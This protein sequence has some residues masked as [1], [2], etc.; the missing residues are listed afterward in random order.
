MEASSTL[1]A[2]A[3]KPR[4]RK[5]RSAHSFITCPRAGN[6]FVPK[7]PKAATSSIKFTYRQSVIL[8]LLSLC[9]ETTANYSGYQLRQHLVIESG[10]YTVLSYWSAWLR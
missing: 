8:R 7:I 10:T 1:Y 2:M 4:E 5:S 6:F 3:V 9:Y